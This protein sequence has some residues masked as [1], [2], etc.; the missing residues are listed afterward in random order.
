M[1]TCLDHPHKVPVVV[2]M[3]VV[4]AQH[5]TVDRRR[6]AGRPAPTG[7]A[8]LVFVGACLQ[9]NR[10]EP[11]VSP[12][13]KIRRQAGSYKGS[14]ACLCRSLPASESCQATSITAGEDSPA[15]RL[16]QGELQLVFVELACKGFV[17]GHG[18]HRRRRFAGRPAPTKSPTP[19]SHPPAASPSTNTPTT[20]SPPRP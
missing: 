18:H 5:S 16:L 9:A 8:R 12:Q 14:S 20:K 2:A 17:P 1:V 7:G 4:I 10:A 6:F 13:A 15:G 3:S 11:Q 19:A